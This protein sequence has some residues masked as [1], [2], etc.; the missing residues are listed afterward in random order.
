MT[1]PF[2][3]G[4]YAALP[5]KR[6]DQEEF[7][8]LLGQTGWTDG[9]EIPY[10]FSLHSDIP[11]LAQQLVQNG[12]YQSVVTCIGGMM[13]TCAKDPDFGLASPDDAA[14]ERTLTYYRTVLDS[15]DQ[16][17]SAAGRQVVFALEVHSAPVGRAQA[18]AF[19]HSLAEVKAMCAAAGLTTVIEHCD[20]ANTTYPGEKRFLTLAEEIG[21]A[22]AAGVNITV[23]WGRSVVETHDAT[24]PQTHLESLVDQDLLGGIMF[25]GAGAGETRYGPDWGDAHLPL[26]TDEPKSWMTPARVASC[27]QI[28]QGH[29]LYKGVKIQTPRTDNAESIQ[30]ISRIY[31][32][33]R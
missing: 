10:I 31:E 3:V 23:N 16:L 15:I 29:E 18:A 11:W 26:S 12:L 8:R 5:E 9:C 30:M 28:A 24:T 2:I 13:Q 32:A 4:A 20:A 6:S 33:M 22:Q 1:T 25:S 19:T 27:W 14:R 17:N 21:A 7:Y